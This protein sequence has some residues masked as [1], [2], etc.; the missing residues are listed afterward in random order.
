ML[1]VRHRRAN[2]NIRKKCKLQAILL[3]NCGS[4]FCHNIYFMSHLKCVILKDILPFLYKLLW[5]FS[6]NEV[7]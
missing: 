7:P 6:N 3:L 4:H 2:G 1:Y 5:L